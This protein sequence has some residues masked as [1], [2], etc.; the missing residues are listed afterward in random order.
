MNLKEEAPAST[1]TSASSERKG[2]GAGI[3][4]LDG[5][6]FSGRRRSAGEPVS[7]SPSADRL[8]VTFAM[9][10]EQQDQQQEQKKAE[11]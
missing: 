10:G 2:S 7:P 4:R 1:S 11:S 3:L 6:F 9:D 5:A 8:S